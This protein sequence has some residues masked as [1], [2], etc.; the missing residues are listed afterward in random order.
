MVRVCFLCWDPVSVLVYSPAGHC[1][2]LGT[3]KA[4]A[5][6][7]VHARGQR[8][9]PGARARVS[10]AF[11]RPHGAP[12]SRVGSV[13][14]SAQLPGKKEFQM[15][16]MQPGSVRAGPEVPAGRLGAV[17]DAFYLLGGRQETLRGER[18]EFGDVGGPRCSVA[19][20]PTL[21]M[22][23]SLTFTPLS[24]ATLWPLFYRRFRP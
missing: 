12:G 1:S 6:R 7:S 11:P 8:S 24:V 5:W 9:P 20:T 17:L 16:L 22:H 14:P 3:C 21:E 13:S 4:S 2:P 15:R 18:D 10:G 19:H 23:R